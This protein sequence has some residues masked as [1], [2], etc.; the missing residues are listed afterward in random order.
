[1]GHIPLFQVVASYFALQQMPLGIQKMIL[2]SKPVFTILF[3]RQG[4]PVL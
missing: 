4:G 3:A 2:S 1:M